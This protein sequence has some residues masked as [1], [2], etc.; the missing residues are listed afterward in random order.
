MIHNC[1]K[2]G[3]GGYPPPHQHDEVKKHIEE[4]LK[5]GTIGKSVSPWASAVVLVRN[6]DGSLRFCI[7]FRML[8][9]RTIKDAYSL[10]RIEDSLDCLDGAQIFTSLG[11][12]A[13]YWQVEMS[14]DSIPYTAFTVG[15]LGFYKCV[16]MPFGLTNAPA[17]FQRLMESCLG[18]PHLKHCIIYLDDIIIFSKT[19]EEHLQRLHEVFEKLASAGL[20]LKP[21]KCEFFKPRIEYLGHIMSKDGIET[22]PR[23]LGAIL[24][25]PRPKTV[26]QVR[27]FLGFCNYYHKFIYKFAQIAK[28]LH[29]LCSGENASRKKAMVL[30]DSDCEKSFLELK[31]RCSKTPILAYANYQ[32]PFKIH[33]DASELGLGAVS[34]QD[35]D[36]G[37]MK[38]IAYMSRTLS[39]SEKKYHSH[40]LEFLA[41]KWAVTER[42]HKYVYGGKFKVHTDN[43]PLTYILTSAKLDATGQR[44]VASLANYEF[45]IFYKSGKQNVEADALSQIEWTLQD[46]LVIKAC[47][48]TGVGDGGLPNPPLGMISNN[49]VNPSPAIVEEQWREEQANDESIGLI[50]ELMKKCQLFKYKCKPEDPMGMNILLKYKNSLLLRKGLLYRK[51]QLKQH[52][53]PILQFVLPSSFQKK[54]FA[55]P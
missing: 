11:L 31:D 9:N 52:E 4:M 23:K 2:R 21:N 3:T 54:T 12:K 20:K 15:P 1:L 48:L 42:F 53:E 25:W 14:E 8:N 38:V 19:P 37:T 50:L 16:W 30:W 43:N 45:K 46:P 28:P 39:K 49:L 13:G 44:W 47:L 34:Y 33:T 40:K 26:T 18:N 27:S 55:F 6:K 17:T 29:K 36:N 7:N 35:Q 51:V 10:P 32:K 22:N 41:L 24:N 5:I